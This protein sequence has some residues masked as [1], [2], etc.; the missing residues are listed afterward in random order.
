MGQPSTLKTTIDLHCLY[1]FRVCCRHMQVDILPSVPYLQLTAGQ[2]LTIFG[3]LKVKMVLLWQDV[4]NNEHI[5]FDKLHIDARIPLSDLYKLQP[6]VTEWV[7]HGSVSCAH[8]DVM[9]MWK[10]NPLVHLQTSIMDLVCGRY[11][12]KHLLDIGVSYSMMRACGLNYDIMG[13][14]HFTFEEWILLG[15]SRDILSELNDKQ[16]YNIFGMS[17]MQIEAGF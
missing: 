5:T 16:I 3:Y 6:S 2:A 9:R 4:K 17:R 13:L 8:V 11:T 14:F 15:M 1:K 7:A 10:L 12:A